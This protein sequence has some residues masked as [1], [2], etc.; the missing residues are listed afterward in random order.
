MGAWSVSITGNDT[1]ADLH[2]EYQAAFSH[3]PPEEAAARLDAFV[4]REYGGP[5]GACWPDYVYSLAMF[6][7]KHGRLTETVRRRALAL[8][9]AGA[10]L[11]LYGEKERRAREK[12]L[13]AFRRMLESPQPAARPIRLKLNQ[14]PVFQVGDVLTLRLYTREGLF[15]PD[16]ALT[17]A[18]FRELDGHWMLLRKVR[19][20]VA[21]QSATVP[22][23]R[24]IWPNFEV[25]NVCAPEVPA[26]EDFHRGRALGVVSGGGRAGIYRRRQ[27]RV[28]GSSLE[29]MPALQE[30]RH[31]GDML[32]LNAG[33]ENDLAEVR[34]LYRHG[35]DL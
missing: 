6:M 12:A 15:Y 20:D 21:W 13:G 31:I 2:G 8:M 1:A 16:S 26:M 29:K 4:E 25:Y 14:T 28:L 24:D 30:E 7:W 27:V 5:D 33:A 3:L 35:L 17:E 32:F 19:D 11:E 23:V 10:G 34:W 22:E 18:A 9:D